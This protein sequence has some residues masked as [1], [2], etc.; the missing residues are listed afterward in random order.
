MTASAST[1]FSEFFFGSI[2]TI[3][4]VLKVL[5]PLMILIEILQVYDVMQK[6]SKKLAAVTKLL[7]MNPPAI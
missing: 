5:I 4:S 1:I 6:L 3:I 2:S 7:G